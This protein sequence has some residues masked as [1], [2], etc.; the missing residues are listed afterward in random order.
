MKKVEIVVVLFV[1]LFIVISC[2]DK[3]KDDLTT[4]FDRRAMLDNMSNNLIVPG[5]SSLFSKVTILKN[6]SETFT[7]SPSEFNLQDLQSKF[8][9]AYLVWQSMEV[10]EFG[11]AS[12]MVLRSSVN[13]F[14]TD[15][16]TIKSN[17]TSGN[18]DLDV[19]GNIR[20]KGFPALEFL[21]FGIGQNNTAIV[22]KYVSDSEAAN[23][24][25]YLTNVLTNMYNRINNV[26]SSWG[27]TYA[28]TFINNA[29]TDLGS[30]VSFLVNNMSMSL[31]SVRRERIGTPLGYVGLV[32][33]GVVSPKLQEAYY[34][35][36]SKELILENLRKTKDLFNGG[37]GQGFDD[38]LNKIN[39]K[40]ENGNPLS[41]EI[42][43]QFDLAIAAVNA[44]NP[45]LTSALTNDN[46]KVEATFLEVKKLVVLIKLD[47]ASQLG[48]VINY[49]DND[50][51]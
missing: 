44:L 36:Y 9:E 2:K 33:T 39:A 49:S 8:K 32:S 34:S 26:N 10:Y 16:A 17:I 50:G 35:N 21:L 27:G 15:T 20:A 3:K 1:S 31:E 25:A 48:V 4:E 41:S 38:Y 19:S 6:T 45:D 13:S 46:Q 40:F 23:R 11:P 47:M 51:D 24:R 12:D 30:S 37:T 22:A 29:G 5:Y 18:Y 42:N 7:N 28:S 43:A 14:P